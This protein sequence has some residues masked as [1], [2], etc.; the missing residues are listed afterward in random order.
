MSPIRI[1]T[2]LAC[3]FL[4]IVSNAQLDSVHY[5]PPF[6]A[7]EHSIGQQ[8]F[9]LSTPSDTDID[10][11]VL[12]SYGNTLDILQISNASPQSYLVGTDNSSRVMTE[13]TEI[14]TPLRNKGY[15]FRS[16]NHFYCNYRVIA[17][18]QSGSIT[19]KGTSAVGYRFRPGHMINSL[20]YSIR[21]NSVSLL[22]LEDAEIKISN[23]PDDLFLENIQ[24][25]NGIVN[26]S[27]T[28]GETFVLS[29]YMSLNQPNN[30]MGFMGS[31]I[32]SSGKIV[33]NCGSYTGGNVQTENSRDIGFDQI[34]P[35]HM[36]GKEFICIRGNGFDLM[37]NVIVII[38]RDS[39]RINVNGNYHGTYA[40][41][42]YV[43]IPESY[44]SDDENL[45]VNATEPVVLYQMIGGFPYFPTYGMNFIPALNCLTDT[46]VNNIPFYNRIGTFNYNGNIIITA[47]KDA[48]VRKNGVM[49]PRS[50]ARSVP[51]NPYYVTYKLRDDKLSDHLTIESSEE[52]QVGLFGAN[53]LVGFAAYF[54][55]F[56]EPPNV[57]FAGLGFTKTQ[58]FEVLRGHGNYERIEWYFQDRLKAINVDT[59][60]AMGPGRYKAIGYFQGCIFKDSVEITHPGTDTVYLEET[61]CSALDTG[62]Y[63]FHD[64]STQDCDSITFKSVHLLRSDLHRFINYTC[65]IPEHIYD[66][67]YFTNSV[68]CDSIHVVEQIYVGLDTICQKAEICEG[69]TYAFEG[70]QIDQSGLFCKSFSSLFGCDSTRC[71]DLNI[72]PNFHE[73]NKDTICW[74]EFLVYEG[75]TLNE[76]GWYTWSYNGVT[77]C[78]S[79]I[80]LLLEL[81]DD[82]S[83]SWDEPSNY[84]LG[85][86]TD[87]RLRFADGFDLQWSDGSGESRR[88]FHHE[89]SLT[90]MLSD[91][92][93][94]SQEYS[95][96]IPAPIDIQAETEAISDYNGYHISCFDS[97]DGWVEL[98]AEGGTEPYDFIWPDGSTGSSRSNLSPGMYTLNVIDRNGCQDSLNISIEEP[99][100]LNL[101]VQSYHIDCLHDKGSIIIENISGGVPEYALSL[102]GTSS[103]VRTFNDL[104]EDVY[105]FVLTDENGCKIEEHIQITDTRD[106]LYLNIVCD[107]LVE[108]GEE[109]SLSYQSSQFLV[110]MQWS[111]SDSSFCNNCL[112]WK[113]TPLENLDIE[114]WGIDARGCENQSRASITIYNPRAVYIPNSF[115]PNGDGRNDF[116]TVHANSS[117]RKILDYKIFNRW[118]GLVYHATNLNANLDARFWDGHQNGKPL[119]PGV[120]VYTIEVE[121]INGERELFSGDVSL[122]K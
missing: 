111:A 16:D 99:E 101:K 57:R 3:L 1:L 89:D 97:N 94:C 62:L 30:V 106:S 11:E 82:P 64:V 46:I 68:G 91:H 10:I 54:S 90:F 15:I 72:I 115:S 84:C 4:A 51:G 63:I 17:F 116:F 28:K 75:D 53:G 73:V 119:N 41:G 32:E 45:Y 33:V 61:S 117:V 40:A 55:G 112:Y 85:G 24:I 66:T 13:R 35:M 104:V 48:A 107:S 96:E 8:Y 74:N 20:H 93:G 23:L 34:I 78:D 44:F 49:L 121:Y 58:C 27:L 69:E 103:N 19:C 37:E 65:Q 50:E 98:S 38:D 86:S 12:D 114:L 21:S 2:C 95:V 25:Q 42:D 83:P 109:V 92:H 122:F 18:P 39:T 6:H 100:E 87:I 7:A 113:F 29:E 76:V 77:H 43:V 70:D 88:H 102:D 9:F 81:T 56:T 71:V 31:L 5:F 110:D 26:L 52:I 59:F 108:L 47:R 120:F 118:G 67:L 79:T 22:A 105:Q 36:A 14:G 60:R 80:E